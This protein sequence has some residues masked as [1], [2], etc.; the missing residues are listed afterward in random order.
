MENVFQ[1]ATAEEEEEE[2]H[3]EEHVKK[4]IYEKKQFN[5]AYV[6]EISSKTLAA[7]GDICSVL[8]NPQRGLNAFY[9]AKNKGKSRKSKTI[10]LKNVNVYNSILKGFAQ[11]GDY[12]K[13]KDVISLIKDANVQRNVQSHIYMLEC[14]GRI[15]I[16]DSRLKDISEYVNE[17][18]KDR[19]SFDQLMNEG[20]F[21]E[22]QRDLVLK[23]MNAYSP[24]YKPKY[25]KP[26]LHY[27]NHLVNQLN[28]NEQ[29]QSLKKVL[30]K[31][32]SVVDATRKQLELEKGGYVT[33]SQLKFNSTYPLL[34]MFCLNTLV[35]ADQYHFLIV[36]PFCPLISV[37][38]SD[39]QYV[40]R[41]KTFYNIEI[42][43]KTNFYLFL[44]SI[45]FVNT[46]S[47]FSRYRG[48]Q[49]IIFITIAKRYISS[50]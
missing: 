4:A 24:S 23:A 32:E 20:A 28:N 44:Q 40:D 16:K 31:E 19:I 13:M 27:S 29:Y 38:H 37:G 21:Y 49:V 11:K 9:F 30:F 33:V 1:A 42:T 47:A 48:I 34:R 17:M 35:L 5:Y 14:L 43:N 41:S 6:E 3:P 25:L 18:F 26:K 10:V 8:K 12:S 46:E 50:P 45:I 22:G 39:L 2:V 15:N 7:Y 36:D